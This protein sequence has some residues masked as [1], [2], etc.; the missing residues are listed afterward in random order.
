MPY[1]HILCE[2]W[3]C[4]LYAYAHHLAKF[5]E[6]IMD[7]LHFTLGKRKNSTVSVIHA[8]SSVVRVLLFSKSLVYNKLIICNM[9]CEAYEIEAKRCQTAC[10]DLQIYYFI[11][12]T[13]LA[14]TSEM[15]CFTPCQLA[16]LICCII[17]LCSCVCTDTRKLIKPAGLSFLLAIAQYILF[18][19]IWHFRAVCSQ[20][21][22]NR[23]KFM[24]C[25]FAEA[26]VCPLF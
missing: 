3:Y 9:Y 23:V 6:N 22:G 20:S 21:L 10:R 24:V 12:L 7:V 16:F 13:K 5:K 26:C 25:S 11:L 2:Q 8:H 15:Y 14:G 4:Q 18:C 17:Q 1:H 19:N